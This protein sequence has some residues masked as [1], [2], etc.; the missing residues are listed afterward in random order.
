MARETYVKNGV[1]L[2]NGRSTVAVHEETRQIARVLAGEWRV[3]LAEAFDIAL[4]KCYEQEFGRSP[5]PK[6]GAQ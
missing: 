4:T 1:S 2:R 6:G 5:K 3:T